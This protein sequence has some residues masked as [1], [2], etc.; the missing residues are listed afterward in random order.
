VG[1]NC[2]IVV[3]APYAEV[4]RSLR[5]IVGEMPILIPGVGAQ[6]GDLVESVQAG[7]NA[8]GTG[9]IINSSRETIYAS[10][11]S[12]FASAARKVAEQLDVTIRSHA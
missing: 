12:D 11:E 1:G 7:M 10:S 6:G 5:A 9:I 4:L 8:N 3:G 2:G